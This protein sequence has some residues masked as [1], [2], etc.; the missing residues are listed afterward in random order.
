MSDKDLSEEPVAGDTDQSVEETQ[1]AAIC[2]VVGP[3]GSGKTLFSLA[4]GR[5]SLS[6]EE[7]FGLRI[8]PL[9]DAE[10]L[11]SLAE[12]QFA[13][14]SQGPSGDSV[15]EYEFEV[16]LPPPRASV[17][18][19]L[20]R[21]I[22]SLVRHAELQHRLNVGLQLVDGPGGA[23]FPSRLERDRIFN[24]GPKLAALVESS[25]SLIFCINAARPDLDALYYNLPVFLARMT[26]RDGYLPHRTVLVLLTHVDQI[27]VRFLQNIHMVRTNFPSAA[28]RFFRDHR[29]SHPLHLA[30]LLDA[31]ELA[32]SL[33]GEGLLNELWKRLAPGGKFGVGVA[34]AAGFDALTGR[35]AY[36]S[37]NTGF[38]S[39]WKPLGIEEALFFSLNGEPAQDRRLGT[40]LEFVK[41]DRAGLPV[42]YSQE[43][44]LEIYT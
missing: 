42:E 35:P 3:S 24:C 29:S 34:S 1:P 21:G 11:R 19:R 17:A 15:T 40:I 41:D 25:Q 16:E 13:S 7:S 20:R 38:P 8:R 14:Y 4:L 5:G 39:S 30:S 9:F 22:E 28:T 26:Q 32:R 44:E 18:Q 31:P 2:A 6:G 43:L 36:D 27:A 33:V 23:L 12:M 10:R 37:A